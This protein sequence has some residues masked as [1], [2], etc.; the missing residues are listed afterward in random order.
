VSRLIAYVLEFLKSIPALLKIYAALIRHLS[1]DVGTFHDIRGGRI[2]EL[3]KLLFP[4]DHP[5]HT[6]SAS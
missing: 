4:W 3:R 2:K 1:Q 6:V 5:K